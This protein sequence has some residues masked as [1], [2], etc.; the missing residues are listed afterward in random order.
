MAVQMVLGSALAQAPPPA[1]PERSAPAAIEIRVV[2]GEGAANN[3]GRDS[4]GIPA[5]KVLDDSEAPVMGATVVFTLPADGPSGEFK[6]GSRTLI[7]TTDA[8]GVAEAHGLRVNMMPGRLAIHVNASYKGM[9]AITNITQFNVAVPGVRA[10]PKGGKKIAVW[11]AAAAG[12]A[13]AAGVV[14]S[15]RSSAGPAGAAGPPPI[16]IGAG[17]ASVGPPR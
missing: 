5:V 16:S 12:G 6:D 8:K 1:A 11:L 3:V 15:R 7:A 9:R 13:A 2:S 14:A 10:A 17:S 4:N